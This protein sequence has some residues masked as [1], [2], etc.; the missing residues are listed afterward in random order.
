MVWVWLGVL[1]VLPLVD[2]PEPAPAAEVT[3]YAF[4]PGDVLE[5]RV[6]RRPELSLRCTVPTEGIVSFPP[7]GSIRIAG[8]DARSLEVELQKKLTSEGV[9]RDP[10]VTVLIQERRPRKVYILDGVKKPAEYT[11]PL[12][13][14]LRLT[15]AI[16]IAGG[17]SPDA[18]R[19][20]VTILRTGPD[21]ERFVLRVNTDLILREGD[22][23]SDLVV[24]PDDTIIVGVRGVDDEK[25]FV[26]GRVKN[27]GAYKFNAREGL[28]VLRAI[29]LAGGFDKFA[30]QGETFI[31]RRHAGEQ[32]AIR[33]D[34]EALLRGDLAKDQELHPNDIVLVPESFF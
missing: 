32:R 18:N 8:R 3:G 5:I 13:Q 27:P 15:Q 11:L 20:N 22:I 6:Y 24:E 31:L 1:W 21:G 25:V 19:E 29:I 4:V 16:S 26:A 33:V 10:K 17:F 14:E 7:L 23:E 2:G 30:A 12:D 34:M 9:I 28:S